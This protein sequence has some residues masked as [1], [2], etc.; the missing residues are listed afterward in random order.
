MNDEQDRDIRGIYARLS[1][2]EKEALGTKSLVVLILTCVTS[3]VSIII[4]WLG[5]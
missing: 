5:G 4:Q 1:T 2:L 3:V